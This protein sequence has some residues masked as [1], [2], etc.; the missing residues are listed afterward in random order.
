M[1]GLET[2]VAELEGRSSLGLGKGASQNALE[3]ITLSQN[4]ELWVSTR[5]L[6][7]V[8]IKVGGLLTCPSYFKFKETRG[9]KRGSKS[10]VVGALG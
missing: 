7:F 9:Q 5:N 2:M 6:H 4:W 1:S 8:Y 3:N 10:K